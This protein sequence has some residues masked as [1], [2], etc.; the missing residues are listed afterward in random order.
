MCGAGSSRIAETARATS[1]DETGEVLPRPIG[2]AS[3]SPSRALA[4]EDTAS[5]HS[6]ETPPPGHW[7][8][9]LA[10]QLSLIANTLQQ[11]EL[12][13]AVQ[14]LAGRVIRKG[15]SPRPLRGA[16]P[17]LGSAASAREPQPLT[18][19]F[20]NALAVDGAALVDLDGTFR[21]IQ[22]GGT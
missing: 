17:V 5:T 21:K 2:S 16:D 19:A 18:T 12:H 14:N 22:R 7:V 10:S 11:G 13:N 6:R 8:S 1:T 4:A 9:G 3:S 15:G 20:R